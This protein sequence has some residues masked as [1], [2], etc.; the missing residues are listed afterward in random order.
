M[1][2]SV[3]ISAVCVFGLFA[4]D[5]Y[6][7]EFELTDNVTEITS[8]RLTFDQ[9]RKF[10]LFEED[11]VVTDP[12]MKLTSDKLTVYFDDDNQARHI[13]AEGNVVIEQEETTAWAG[14]ATYDVVSGEVFLED[15]PRIRRGNDILEGETITFWRD[16]NR[17]ICEP[18]ARLVIY[19]DAGG[20]RDRLFGE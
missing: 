2:L 11:V 20:A 5:A 19:P 3:W 15:G 10:A 1:K 9:D 18:R 7:E 17:M 12:S 13:E 6:A 16:D 4:F 14:K 8:V